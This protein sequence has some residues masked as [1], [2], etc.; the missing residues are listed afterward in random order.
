MKIGFNFNGARVTASLED[1]ATSRDL[2]AMLPLTL[3]LEDFA[4]TEKI[5]YLPQKLDTAGAPSGIAPDAGD[6]AYYA[7][8]GNLAFFH[9]DFFHSPG[10]VKFGHIDR[11]LAALRTAGSA[12]VIIECEED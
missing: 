10:L 9:A 11:G 6:L 8:W 3:R 7:P 12:E 5:A 1:N 4:A 2:I